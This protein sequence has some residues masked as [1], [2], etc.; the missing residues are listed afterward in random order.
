MK[1]RL[2][3]EMEDGWMDKKA[4]YCHNERER[5]GGRGSEGGREAGR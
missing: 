2:F 3:R 1:R 5:E 4:V